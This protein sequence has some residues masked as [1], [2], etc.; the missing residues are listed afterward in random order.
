[1][2]N[3]QPNKCIRVTAERQETNENFERTADTKSSGDV[4][5]AAERLPVVKTTCGALKGCQKREEHVK[6]WR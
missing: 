4:I 5:S 6:G 2:P 3:F 1:M